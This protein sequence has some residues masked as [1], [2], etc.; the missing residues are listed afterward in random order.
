MR[1]I[2]LTKAPVEGHVKTRLTPVFTAKEATS[3]HIKM[4]ETVLTNVCNLFD[5]V[6]LAAD[7]INHPYF[8]DIT[9]RFNVMIKEQ[10]SGDL[11]VR[12]RRLQKLSFDQDESPIM[13]LGTDSPHAPKARYTETL[14][15]IK[16]QDVVIGPVEDGGYDLI[17]MR[18]FYPGI[19]ENISWGTEFVYSQ[20][21]NYINTLGLSVHEL[22]TSF[23]LD[24]PEDI[25]RAPIETWTV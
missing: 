7:N 24:R 25:Q 3:I 6:W 13:F 22:N 5:D 1:T 12:L 23:D 4:I 17:A 15:N 19:F 21:V 2:I 16:T 20:T 11:G 9:K 8:K 18:S 10:G 14:V